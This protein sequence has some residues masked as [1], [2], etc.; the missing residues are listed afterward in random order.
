VH[1]VKARGKQYFYF[2]RY[3]GTEREEPRIKL[4]CEPQDRDG[5]PNAEW[6]RIYRELAD[7]L[8]AE[9]KRGSFG[10]LIAAYKESP[11]WGE[12]SRNTRSQRERYLA[13]IEAAWGNLSVAGLEARHVLQRRD[14]WRGEQ[15]C[16]GAVGAG[17]I[18]RR[19]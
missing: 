3:R 6:W 19:G 10:A 7:E 11:E 1:A 9:P 13:K 12:L 4:P 17:R 16:A 2:Q 15:R 8:E 18:S 5:M 14:T